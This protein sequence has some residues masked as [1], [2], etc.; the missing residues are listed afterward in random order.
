MKPSRPFANN[1]NRFIGKKDITNAPP[2]GTYDK[3]LSWK[4]AGVVKIKDHKS[5]S[6]LQHKKDI[7]GPG[8][9]NVSKDLLHKGRVNPYFIMGGSDDRFRSP[10][11]DVMPGPGQYD[12][13]PLTGTLIKP[14]YNAIMVDEI[15]AHL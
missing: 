5:Q 7:P 10:K 13:T 2:P 9:Y 4:A 8:D 1:E 14:T 12:P 11:K 3:P 6:L 15:S